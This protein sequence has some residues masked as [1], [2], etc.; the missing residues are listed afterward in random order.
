MNGPAPSQAPPRNQAAQEAR[1]SYLQIKEEIMA[2]Y[3]NYQIMDE[4]I[5]LVGKKHIGKTYQQVFEDK[6][7][8]QWVK[9]HVKEEGASE[10]QMKF[11]HY[12]T[13]KEQEAEAEPEPTGQMVPVEMRDQIATLEH[14]VAALHGLQ[15]EMVELRA[16]QRQDRIQMGQR[17]DQVEDLLQVLVELINRG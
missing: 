4:L 17:M 3:P 7:Y 2:Q 12:V 10:E 15:I 11:L 5:Y 8:L 14:Q 6:S 9:T 16:E 13:L 1:P